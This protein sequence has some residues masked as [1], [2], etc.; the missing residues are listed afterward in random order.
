MNLGKIF[1]FWYNLEL[2]FNY[3][4]W[5]SFLSCFTIIINSH[6]KDTENHRISFCVNG[7]VTRTLINSQ[8]HLRNHSCTLSSD[9]QRYKYWNVAVIFLENLG[10][11]TSLSVPNWWRD[12][13]TIESITYNPGTLY[14]GLHWK[15]K[16]RPLGS[17]TQKT[18]CIHLSS[19]Q[20]VY[21]YYIKAGKKNTSTPLPFVSKTTEASAYVDHG[22]YKSKQND[23]FQT[24][25]RFNVYGST[26]KKTC[27]F[28]D[29]IFF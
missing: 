25:H 12:W 2:P 29:V 6:Y 15:Q 10:P 11:K 26:T 4:H 17:D 8:Q 22:W 3:Y 24:D 28:A 19:L 9:G 21:S 27:S 1:T 13:R 14:S 23:E 18:A 20:G 16:K 7:N 5:Q